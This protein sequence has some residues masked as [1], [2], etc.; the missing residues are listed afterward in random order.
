MSY[1]ETIL[2]LLYVLYP[3][4]K[5]EDLALRLLQPLLEPCPQENSWFEVMYFKTQIELLLK[6]TLVHF[7][8]YSHLDCDLKRNNNNEGF[9]DK[10]E[11]EGQEIPWKGYC[12]YKVQDHPWSCFPIWM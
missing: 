7:V 6:N 9:E 4:C 5:K 1:N 11:Q 8:I 12:T 10:E 3:T 2:L